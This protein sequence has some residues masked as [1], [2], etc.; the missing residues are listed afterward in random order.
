FPSLQGIRAVSGRRAEP[1]IAHLGE[2]CS[3]D[4]II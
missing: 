1:G 3:T 2:V 4:G